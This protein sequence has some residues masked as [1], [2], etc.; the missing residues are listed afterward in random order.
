MQQL[1]GR[2]RECRKSGMIWQGGGATAPAKVLGPRELSP[3][4]VPGSSDEL[5]AALVVMV[6]S[7]VGTPA[8]Q[9][10]VAFSAMASRLVW[11]ATRI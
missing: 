5:V 4:E 7:G 6:A 11:I 1:A 2:F 9:R 10:R 8:A 3:V